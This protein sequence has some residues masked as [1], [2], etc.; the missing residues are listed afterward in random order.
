MYE[1]AVCD[2]P[3]FPDRYALT[4]EF[5][6]AVACSWIAPE[7]LQSFQDQ[8]VA[9]LCGSGIDW[10]DFLALVGRHGIPVQALTVLRRC[11]GHGMPETS[12]RGLMA[13]GRNTSI[14]SLTQMAELVRIS[15]LLR[16]QGIEI[17]PLKG[18]SLS[19]RL[20]GTPFVRSACDID[21][22]IRPENFMAAD[23]TL[24]V[25]GY[26]NLHALTERQTTAFLAH[27]QHA[28]YCHEGSGQRLELH[29]RCHSWTRGEMEVF[30]QDQEIVEMMGEQ[31]AVPAAP[32]LFLFLCYHG[33]RHRW[34][35]LKWLGDAAAMFANESVSDWDALLALA[36]RL[37]LLRVLAQSALLVSWLYGLPLPSRVSELVS[38]EK[39]SR[40]LAKKS[41]AALLED[42]QKYSSRG[43][44]LAS[45]RDAVYFK[46]IRPSVPFGLFLKDCFIC[47]VDY[48][49]F[50]L[51]DR[52]F[53]MYVPL[54]PFFWFW[55]HF[56][57]KLF[58]GFRSPSKG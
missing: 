37:G 29:V 36:D 46:R 15:R 28:E 43:R 58:T 10:E 48:I 50:P 44:R 34:Y 3:P 32:L 42:A 4:P 7:P 16:N 57:V 45:L 8:T 5:R 51:P 53:W 6:L 20:Y 9:S 39:T 2:L 47:P 41:V 11:Q 40:P 38:G 54:R 23:R 55:R 13:R 18:E 26:R 14:R 19:Q 35:R 33:A 56:G 25:S 17:I 31:F 49:T 22:L 21:V 24:S 12:F 30:W 27:C 52:L 1:A